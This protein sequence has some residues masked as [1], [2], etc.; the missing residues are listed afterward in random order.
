MDWSNFLKQCLLSRFDLVHDS[1]LLV[2]QS[3]YWINGDWVW[4]VGAQFR[5]EFGYLKE[6]MGRP[7]KYFVG[8][9]CESGINR[10][11]CLVVQSNMSFC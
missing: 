8:C 5:F 2:E 7:S 3:G 4:N 10:F 1:R 9:W 11:V 6:R